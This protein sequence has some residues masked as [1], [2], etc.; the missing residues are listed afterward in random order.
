MVTFV[1]TKTHIVAQLGQTY[2]PAAYLE[3]G[4]YCGA[5]LCTYRCFGSLKRNSCCLPAKNGYHNEAIGLLCGKN[6]Y[7][8]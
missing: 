2:H 8:I 6:V 4:I 1:I 5:R 7:P 3:P